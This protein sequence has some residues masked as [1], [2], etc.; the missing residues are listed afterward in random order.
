M[1]GSRTAPLQENLKKGNNSAL[2]RTLSTSRCSSNVC[3]NFKVSESHAFLQ[4]VLT[5]TN[6]IF[7]LVFCNKRDFV[8]DVQTGPPI[9][10]SDHAT[11]TF[12]LDLTHKS[13][14]VR[15]VRNFKHADYNQIGIFLTS[16]D[17]VG[18][19]SSGR[20]VDIRDV[21]SGPSPCNQTVCSYQKTKW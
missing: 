5:P 21:A 3:K 4:W 18:I 14:E 11:V 15:W 17:W 1:D 12:C 10:S 16:I 20:T 19:M 7:D 8:S 9:G 13:K 6:S 2:K